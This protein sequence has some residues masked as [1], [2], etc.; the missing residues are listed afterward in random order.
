MESAPTPT[1]GAFALSPAAV[2]GRRRKLKLVTRKVARKALKK[3][4]LKMRGGEDA[5]TDG[6]KVTPE[7]AKMGGADLASTP[8]VPTGGRRRRHGGKTKKRS[9]SRR[10]SSIFG[11]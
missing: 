9:A 7:M 3:M 1:G 4:G 5:S 2:G 10:R 8:D 11:L 6:V